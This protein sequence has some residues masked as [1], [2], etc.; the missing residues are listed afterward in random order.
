MSALTWL[1]DK[2]KAGRGW[3]TKDHSMMG[4][5]VLLAQTSTPAQ[6]YGGTSA[7]EQVAGTVTLAANTI[8]ADS[9]LRIS[10]LCNFPT[11]SDVRGLSIYLNNVLIGQVLPDVSIG[12]INWTYNIFVL[13]DLTGVAVYSQSIN[14]VLAPTNGQ[15]ASFSSHTAAKTS[16]TVDMSSTVIIE[17]KIQPTNTDIAELSAWAIESLSLSEYPVVSMAPSTAVACWGDSLTAGTGASDVTLTSYPGQLLSALRVGKITSNLGIG[18][19]T[20][21]Q[22]LAR[23]QA[24]KVRGRL[25]TCIF[26]MGRNDVG[27]AD[28]AAVV[29]PNVALAVANLTHV[30]Y[31]V[32]SIL[33]AA[34]ETVGNADR[35]KIIAANTALSTTYSTKYV[36]LM[37][38][39]IG[40]GTEIPISYRA[41]TASTTGTYLSGVSTITVTSPTGIVNG[42]FVSGT[43]IPDQTTITIAGSV[44]TLSQPTTGAGTGATLSFVGAAEIHLNDAGYAVVAAAYSTALTTNSW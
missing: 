1:I 24:D 16:I 13:P 32:G 42:Q 12:S 33:S 9:I 14:D 22:I 26:Q 15:G 41:V 3:H 38:A 35:T 34:N 6:V 7:T 20:S 21:T 30:R 11:S 17:L 18:S 36:N 43:G 31:L 29:S 23:I 10:G 37:S 5:P 4:V 25:W 19:Q 27:A 2:A 28:L 8:K 44:I 40:V 39:L